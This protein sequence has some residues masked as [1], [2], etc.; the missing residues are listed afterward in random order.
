M[1]IGALAK[2]TGCKVVTIR[3]YEQEGLLAEPERSDSNYRLYGHED[4]ERLKFIRHCR[5]HDMKLDE[6]RRLLAYRDN[7]EHDCVW[8]S[9]L[10]DEHITNVDAQIHSLEQ[11]KHYLQELRQRCSGGK[12]G[13]SCA[14][15]Q[16]L[17]D[18][19]VCSCGQGK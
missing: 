13:D 8:V 16:G 14:I 10:L 2:E 5:K 17:S 18:P 15:M 19:A 3:Y 7:P 12:S 9:D 6:I 4:V 1:R 11:L